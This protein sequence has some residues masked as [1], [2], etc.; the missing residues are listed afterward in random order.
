M[1]SIEKILGD[2]GAVARAF[3]NYETRREQIDMARAVETAMASARHL[4]VEAGTG[5]G[6]TFAYLVPIM[7]RIA[8]ERREQRAKSERQKA[9]STGQSAES[10]K[11]GSAD[12]PPLDAQ[13]TSSGQSSMVQSR[14]KPALSLPKGE[15]AVGV[16]PEKDTARLR[17]RLGFEIEP[18]RGSLEEEDSDAELDGSAEEAKP[19]RTVAVISTNTINL[20]E[21]LIDKD[22]PFLLK[23]LQLD[24]R[25]ALV[26][27]RGNFICLR[28][29]ANAKLRQGELFEDGKALE[30]LDR[31]ADWAAETADGSRSDLKWT[32]ASEAWER[33]CCEQGN[34]HGQRCLFREGCFFQRMRAALRAAD[35]V[36]VNHALFFADLAVRAKGGSLLPQCSIVV[37][38]EGHSLEAVA[39]DQLGAN[40]SSFRV[41][42]LLHQLFNPRTRKGFLAYQNEDHCKG[43]VPKVL[44]TAEHFFAG[45]REKYAAAGSLHLRV[46]APGFVENTLSPAMLHLQAALEDLRKEL[47]KEEFRNVDDC[48]ELANFAGRCGEIAE[49]CAFFLEQS[50]PN[51][52]Y[53]LET[54]GRRGADIAMRS[55]P[56]VVAD[57]LRERVFSKTPTAVLTSATLS[58][59]KE[60]SFQYVKEQLGLDKPDE[61]QL[62]SPF[63]YKRQVRL[64]ICAG[65]PSP[66]E[67]AEFEAAAPER[68]FKYLQMSGGRAFVLFTSYDLLDKVH[69]ALA[70]RLE[71]MNIRVLRQGDGLP[72]HLMLKRFKENIGSVIFGADS[73]WQGVDVPGE[74]LENVIIARLPFP[75]PRDPL[76][77]AKSEWLTR[78]GRDPFREYS[79]PEAVM[80]LKQGFGRLIRAKTDKGIVVILDSRIKTKWYG[81]LFLDSLPECEVVI[82][83]ERPEQA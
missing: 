70:Q 64:F 61:L 4:I 7:L 35:I 36:V 49:E 37:F 57:L 58:I 78:Q 28:R 73:F 47:V 25:I 15:G 53:W 33:V 72:R 82:E 19:K 71:Q 38:D 8:A 20:Q 40:V 12:R 80:K 81:R 76:V 24:L 18:G 34:C 54:F 27:G 45:L 16:P 75:V 5:V 77:E 11:P 55:A 50:D 30:D 14:D 52:A 79:L 66:T 17:S 9:E 62:G 48:Y 69:E 42:F 10:E 29:L 63:D 46:R 39:R 22:I 56:V 59:G 74:A 23:A 83:K 60:P 26:K 67:K 51:Q 2:H 68:V 13:Y 1:A 3:R 43:L 32:P 65:M 44:K 31:L 6:K 21:Q 41:R